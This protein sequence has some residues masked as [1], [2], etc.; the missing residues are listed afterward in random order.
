MRSGDA[1]RVKATELE[2]MAG[3]AE[4]MRLR[5]DL[6]AIAAQYEA[7]ARQAD[8]WDTTLIGVTL[9]HGSD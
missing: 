6:L 3:L 1:Y 7:L 4:T 8:E 2:A 9:S 5:I